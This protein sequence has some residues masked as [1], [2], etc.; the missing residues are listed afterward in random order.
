MIPGGRLRPCSSTVG[1]HT[2]VRARSPLDVPPDPLRVAFLAGTL[3]FGGAE[4]QLVY[5]ARALQEAGL[6]VRVYTLGENEVNEAPLRDAGLGPIGV[7]RAAHPILRLVTFV[8]ALRHFRPHI[9]QAA[10]FYVNLYVALASR[11]FGSL[12]IG[13][14][15]NDGVLELH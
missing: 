12:A 10:T 14:M 15:R 9:I 7:G 13:A 6:R 8:R 1:S 3:E 5:M 2:F 11:L 4:K